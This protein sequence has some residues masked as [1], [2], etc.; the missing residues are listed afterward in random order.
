[1]WRSRGVRP[2][3]VVGM[4]AGEF[5]AA[6]AAG[7][8]GIEDVMNVACGMSRVIRRKLGLGRMVSI[9][10][11]LEEAETLRCIAP[12]PVYITA[13]YSPTVTMLSGEE[14]AIEAVIAILAERG[15][16][17]WRIP[18]DFAFHSPLVDGGKEEFMR[19]LLGLRPRPAIVPIYSSVI[20]GRLETA[21]FDALHWWHVFRKPAFFA[22]AVYR[23]LQ[24]N[25]DIFLEIGNHPILSGS[26]QETASRLN[27]RVITLP[28]MRRD[29]SAGIVLDESLEALR[30]LGYPAA[31]PGAFPPHDG[32]SVP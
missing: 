21:G 13:E 12:R 26:I 22:G 25:Y 14:A 2:D 16:K 20:A 24:D 32:L 3:A 7:V 5:A 27:K 19:N 17:Y 4:S 18:T 31:L 1:V 8:L 11:G 6:Y 30:S 23:L 29:R 15:I 9:S 10:V 28:S